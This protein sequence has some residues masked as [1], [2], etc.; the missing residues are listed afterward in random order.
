PL[1]DA[2]SG[3]GPAC[4]AQEQKLRIAVAKDSAFC[5]FYPLDAMLLE[6]LGCELV[7]FSPIKGEM[8]PKQI[9][10]LILPGGYP[11]LYAKAISSNTLFLKQVKEAILEGLPTIAECGGFMVLHDAI[12]APDG[13]FYPMAGLINGCCNKGNRLMHFGYVSLTAAD[14][15]LVAEK[16]SM[17]RAHEF[18]YWN[19]TV[20]GSS[21]KVEKASNTASW[22][23]G[24]STDSLYAGFPHIPLSANLDAAERFVSKAIS[25]KNHL[26]QRQGGGI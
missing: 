15:G 20:P 23:T 8:L 24:Y 18:H 11:E 13:A 6:Q 16:G 5:F 19:S 17:L 25:Y 10:G 12:E 14:D 22:E 4:K 2:L 21:F 7:Y 1:I 26:D 9:C 3:K